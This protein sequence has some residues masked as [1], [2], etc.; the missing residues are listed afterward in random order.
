MMI[1]TL[2]FIT[3]HPLTRDRPLAALGRFMRWQ[4]T[5]RLREEILVNWL[6]GA[7][8]AARNGMTGATGNIYCGLHEFTDMAFVLH[9]LQPGDLFVDAGANI[10]SYT[11]LAAKVCGAEVLAVEPDPGTMT[12][13]RRNLAVNGIEARVETAQCALGARR[14]TVRFTVGQ[15]TTN[16]VTTDTHEKAT[17][18]VR[19]ESLDNLLAG[20]KP[21]LLKLD[22]E[23]YEAEVLSGAATALQE[24]SL[25]AVQTETDSPSVRD[26]LAGTGFTEV[27]YD[28]FVRA[29]G[30]K[31]DKRIG[32]NS[33]FVRDTPACL[34]RIAHAPHRT[35]LGHWI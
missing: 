28:P 14:G 17:R 25:V 23:G 13:L 29:F 8:L 32:S 1:R 11:I 26:I 30:P 27:F 24:Q 2:N 9:V 18:E 16:C 19:V 15:D 12:F 3:D 5:S 35:V 31:P 34:R 4:I 33:L 22:V 7:R 20:R 10:G 6:E 21:S